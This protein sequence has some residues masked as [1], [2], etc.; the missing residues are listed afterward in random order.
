M[1]SFKLTRSLVARQTPD[2]LAKLYNFDLPR[3]SCPSTPSR[4]DRSYFC[5]SALA[6]LLFGTFCSLDFFAWHAM[7]LI[8]ESPTRL[9]EPR[10][11]TARSA[12]QM[13]YSDFL[14]KETK[15]I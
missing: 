4:V 11:S 2:D 5:T 9:T 6:S 1:D 13:S 14:K 12:P 10:T 7:L 3:V 15:T 8:H